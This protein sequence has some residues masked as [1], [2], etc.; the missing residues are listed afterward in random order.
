MGK[1]LEGH[2]MQLMEKWDISTPRFI[3]AD[4]LEEFDALVKENGW[5]ENTRLVVKAHEAIGG[6]GLLGL[7]K[8]GNF[9]F[10]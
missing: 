5:L 10:I 7:V 9:Q 1:V 8:M 6:R 4:S 3:L 2:T